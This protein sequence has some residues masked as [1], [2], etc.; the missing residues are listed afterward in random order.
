MKNKPARERR[1][2]R[3]P[4]PYGRKGKTEY[5]YSAAHAAWRR[6]VMPKATAAA[7]RKRP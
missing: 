1:R 2:L 5:Q 3:V 6:S 4:G 7:E